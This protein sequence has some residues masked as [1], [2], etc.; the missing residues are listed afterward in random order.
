MNESR[1]TRAERAHGEAQARRDEARARHGN[2]AG[3]LADAEKQWAAATLETIELD[4]FARLG[5]RVELLRR[6]VAAAWAELD[7]VELPYRAA[8]SDLATVR[9]HLFAAQERLDRAVR[10][11]NVAGERDARRAIAALTGE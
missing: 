4:A 6:E 1:M 7:R 8:A 10:N 2:A 11:G 9:Q 3:E 5:A